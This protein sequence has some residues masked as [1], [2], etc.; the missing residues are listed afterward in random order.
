MHRFARDGRVDQKGRHKSSPVRIFMTPLRSP[1]KS[2]IHFTSALM[3]G[4]APY[5]YTY[6]ADRN[7]IQAA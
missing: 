3:T 4:A 7:N 1:P 6:I 5:E 2:A